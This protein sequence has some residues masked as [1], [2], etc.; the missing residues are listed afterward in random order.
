VAADGV[1]EFGAEESDGGEGRHLS[2]A[3]VHGAARRGR[4]KCQRGTGQRGHS[5]TTQMH[6][7]VIYGCIYIGNTIHVYWQYMHLI[8]AMCQRETGQRGD[9]GTKQM[10]VLERS[11]YV[12]TCDSIYTEYV[13]ADV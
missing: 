9:L 12:L 3:A 13:C 8:H 7:S 11:I 2:A 6:I 5:G 4:A 1:G 10:H